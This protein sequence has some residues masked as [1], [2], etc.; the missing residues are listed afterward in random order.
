MNF[1]LADQFQL[2]I[3]VVC[4]SQSPVG[5]IVELG[6]DMVS[7]SCRMSM[8]GE[9]AVAVSVMIHVSKVMGTVQH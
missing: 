1:S 3:I 6:F 5:E 7:L 8:S 9:H 4:T 2:T